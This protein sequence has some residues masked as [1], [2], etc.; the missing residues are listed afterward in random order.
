MNG[1]R[2]DEKR[3]AIYDLRAAAEAKAYAETALDAHPTP[4]LRDALLDAQLDLA[5]KTAVAV[6]ACHACDAP[7]HDHEPHA[8]GTPAPRER[9]L[10]R[11][12]VIDV[13]FGGTS[14]RS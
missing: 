2:P 8:G 4:I 1:D 6:R 3:A 12:N 13:D 9:S 11:S 10:E 14:G 7:G 5:A